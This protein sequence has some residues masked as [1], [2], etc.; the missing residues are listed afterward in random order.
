ML[1][2]PES[3]LASDAFVRF[4]LRQRIAAASRRGSEVWVAVMAAAPGEATAELGGVPPDPAPAVVGEVLASV[5]GRADVLGR[6]SDGHFL[7]LFDGATEVEVLQA[8]APLGALSAAQGGADLRLHGGVAAFPRHARSADG[9][10]GA[11]S[12]ALAEARRWPLHRV[13]VAPQPS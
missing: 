13:E 6:L 2:D 12:A 4:A 11:A 3:G 5:G 7:L 9:V 8:L 1:F 10:I